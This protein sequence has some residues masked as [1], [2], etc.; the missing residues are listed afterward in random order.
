MA[1]CWPQPPASR[2]RGISQMFGRIFILYKLYESEEG[3][4]P[5][6]RRRKRR[7]QVK[8]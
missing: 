5:L 3:R 8:D 1:V 7:I 4:Q 6:T 2:R